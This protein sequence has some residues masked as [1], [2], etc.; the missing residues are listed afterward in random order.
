MS[1]TYLKTESEAID[2]RRLNMSQYQAD[3]TAQSTD[4]SEQAAHYPFR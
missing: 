4:G 3:L 1:S 2:Y